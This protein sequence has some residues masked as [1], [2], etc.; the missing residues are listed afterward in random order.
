MIDW[1]SIN[2]EFNV[3]RL[4]LRNEFVKNHVRTAYSKDYLCESEIDPSV[5]VEHQCHYLLD[6][7]AVA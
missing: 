1:H 7:A 5:I 2:T 4:T 6:S 3:Y